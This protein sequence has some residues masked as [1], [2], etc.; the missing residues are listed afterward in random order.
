MQATIITD[1]TYNISDKQTQSGLLECPDKTFLHSNICLVFEIFTF[2]VIM[3]V[4]I[5]RAALVK[6]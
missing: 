3:S 5:F 1:T 6:F 4:D 2:E